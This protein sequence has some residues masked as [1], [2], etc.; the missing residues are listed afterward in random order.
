MGFLK[1]EELLK[2]LHVL[3]GDLRLGG[4]CVA[5]C[6]VQVGHQVADLGAVV[7]GCVGS[8]V[9]SIGGG[10]IVGSLAH[11]GE[12][13]LNGGVHSLLLFA[14]GVGLIL[15]GFR[16]LIVQRVHHNAEDLIQEEDDHRQQHN[17][18]EALRSA[19]IVQHIAEAAPNGAL[20]AVVIAHGNDIGCAVLCL[21][22]FIGVIALGG[23]EVGAVVLLIARDHTVAD[24]LNAVG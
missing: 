10:N 8:I 6:L 24:H 7:G 3:V 16:F 9:R 21:I 22:H 23:V 4:L 15:N 2:F 17:Q 20:V 1:G 14:L 19:Q 18:E 13:S 11:S 5:H 12:R